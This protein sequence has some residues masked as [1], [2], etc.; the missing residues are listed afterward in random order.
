LSEP[1]EIVTELRASPKLTV[2]WWIDC[3]NLGNN[4]DSDNPIAVVVPA[5]RGFEQLDRELAIKGTSHTLRRIA[6]G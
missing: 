3:W 5:K 6:S 2:N 4:P 1:L